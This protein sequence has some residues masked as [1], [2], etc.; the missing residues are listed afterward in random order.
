MSHWVAENVTLVLADLVT[1]VLAS[2]RGEGDRASGES[3]S[4]TLDGSGFE[5]TSQVGR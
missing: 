3:E 1:A 5:K 2:A 4:E